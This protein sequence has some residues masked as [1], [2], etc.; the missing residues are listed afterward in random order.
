MDNKARIL[1]IND[2]HSLVW[3]IE[4]VLQ[5]EGYDV[6]TTFDG[7]VGLKK[8]REEKPDLVILDTI[9]PKV[10]GYR[11][12]QQL[13]KDP[14]TVHIPVLFTTIK[15]EA[16]EKR[17]IALKGY[18]SAVNLHNRQGGYRVGTYDFLAEPFSAIELKDRVQDLLQLG[19]L[20]ARREEKIR[21]KGR[22][23]I[24]DDN[25]SLVLLAERAL[26]KEGYNAIT[27]FDGLE[28]LRKVRD[29]KPDLIILDIIMP[30]L[31]G[32]QVLDLIRQHSNIPVIMLTSTG[33]VEA[34]KRTLALGA[35]DYVVKPVKTKELLARVQTKLAREEAG[36]P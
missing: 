13:Q 15:G 33:E 6:L 4:R 18:R 35:D 36:T 10:D 34:V 26:Q 31:D 32:F 11:V 2:R 29:E 28:G 12:Y 27:A 30:E 7:Q 5:R 1:I 9:M 19:E 23:L 8:V 22:I 25:R 24:V 3:F 16:E 20:R 21:R 14:D 17:I